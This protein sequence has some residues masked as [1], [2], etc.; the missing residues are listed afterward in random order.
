M[1]DQVMNPE[2]IEEVKEEV[3]D[4]FVPKKAF[5]EVTADMFKYKT[6]LKETESQLIQMKA[7][8]EAAEVR[9]LEENNQ[10]KVL[11]EKK[12]VEAEQ[13]AQARQAEQ[14]KFVGVHKKNAVLRELGGFKKEEYNTFINITNVEIDENGNIVQ[15][16]LL[17]EVNRLKQSYPELIKSSSAQ[18]LP[19]D[20]PRSV[21]LPAKEYNSLSPKEKQDL[22]M[23]LLLNKS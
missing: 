17:G 10:W 23:K 15:D 12:K 3:K 5:T 22:K 13:I 20:A 11:Y 19:S 8:R 4:E 21:D 1:E 7:E 6:K 18:N 2:V 9:S 14:D 16:S